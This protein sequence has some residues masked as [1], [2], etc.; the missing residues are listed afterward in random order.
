VVLITHDH[1][2]HLGAST[3]KK[4]KGK[5]SLFLVPLGI[6]ELFEE[7]GIAPGKIV[8]LDWWEHHKL[9]SL[10]FTATQAIHYAGR[11]IFDRNKRINNVAE[12][13][14]GV[15]GRPAP[16]QCFMLNS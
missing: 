8:E 7:W 5:T 4:L 3:I 16:F 6:G 1:Y 10:L 2:D 12:Q 14:R 11:G 13:V 9:G 15:A